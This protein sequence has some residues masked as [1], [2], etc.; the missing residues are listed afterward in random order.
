[1]AK[2]NF[3]SG[4]YYGK[5]GA[6]VGQRWKNKRTIRTY[7]KPSNPRTEKQQANRKLFGEFTE[8]SQYGMQMN[9]DSSVWKSSTNTQWALRMSTASKLYKQ[10]QTE[11]N[12][13]P[14]FPSDYTPQYNITK[15]DFICN[16]NDEYYFVKV[17]GNLPENDDSLSVLVGHH[18]E[19]NNFK[20]DKLVLGYSVGLGSNLLRIRADL[21]SSLLSSSEFLLVTRADISS[22]DTV[23]YGSQ[24]SWNYVERSNS[25]F[26]ASVKSFSESEITF[27]STTN[28]YKYSLSVT[29]NQ[30]YEDFENN[31][32]VAEV[33]SVVNGIEN[34]AYFTN[35]T[36]END[37]GYFKAVFEF[38]ETLPQNIPAFPSGHYVGFTNIAMYNDSNAL[39]GFEVFG[40]IVSEN[41]TRQYKSVLSSVELED[42]LIKIYVE[43]LTANPT[44]FSGSVTVYA[45]QSESF[46]TVELTPTKVVDNIIY[47]QQ[48]TSESSNYLSFPSGSTV[49]INVS[50]IESGVTYNPT[51]T[52]AQEV[53]TA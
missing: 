37:N 12:L 6:T 34:E 24:Q 33:V 30:S 19:E 21:D 14:L 31:L 16:Y 22:R 51:I 11:M 47:C 18:D 28:K 26:D 13:I 50:Y 46:V 2:Q 43:D 23:M 32:N 41:L 25:I 42:N 49:A 9:Y 48:P 1:M 15:M 53:P 20:I 29:F 38:E 4:G 35:I 39:S 10:G 40:D 44:S 17:A 7:V 8:R 27:D 5:L 36:F 52:T 3:I 45:Q